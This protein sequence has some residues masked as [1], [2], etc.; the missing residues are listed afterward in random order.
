MSATADIP[1]ILRAYNGDELMGTAGVGGVA[2]VAGDSLFVRH[3]HRCLQIDTATGEL[4]G[5]FKTPDRSDGKPATWGFIACVD[6]VLVGG[7]ADAEHTVTYRYVNRGG[8]MRRLLTESTG[9]F[10]IDVHSGKRLW[11]YEAE[12][13]IRHNAVALADGHVFLVD[14]PA[15]L[16]DRQKKPTGKDHPAGK[17]LAL[18]LRTGKTRWHGNRDTFGTLLAAAPR[19]GALLVGYQPTRFRLDS[20]F[21]GRMAVY[22][23]A[24]GE[25][26]WDKPVQYASRPII[27]GRTILAQ[28]GAWDL[29]SGEPQPFD[30]DRSYGCGILAGGRH[31]LVF[32]S[33]TLG[34]Y[35]LSGKRTTENYG[36]VRPACWINAIPAGGL[37]LSPE[38]TAGCV[39][40]Y[41][42]QTWFALE[43]LPE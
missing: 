31:M 13:S 22:R 19:H 28:G 40:S 43:P 17:L 6:G 23:T 8:D 12:H 24:D 34:Y 41:L 27:N 3:E 38:A 4:L 1:G 42:N 21:G 37:V 36:G 10:A 18:D 2:C 33:A 29:L 5:E 14:R 11:Q 9:L 35:D 30:F 15:A 39:C 25:L 7:T 32:R 20:E 26:L 16:F